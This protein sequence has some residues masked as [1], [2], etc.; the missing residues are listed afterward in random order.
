MQATRPGCGWVRRAPCGPTRRGPPANGPRCR[1][2]G[3]F[4]AHRLGR[5]GLPGARLGRHA[6][7]A[8]TSG[9]FPRWIRPDRLGDRGRLRAGR[10][11]GQPA[12]QRPRRPPG[13]VRHRRSDRQRAE[14]PTKAS[15]TFCSA[16]SIGWRTATPSSTF[17]PVRSSAS[18]SRS[19]PRELQNL[20]YC[21]MFV[22]PGAAALLG[23][24]RLLDPPQLSPS[25]P[26]PHAHQSHARPALPERR[27]VFRHLPFR[28][29]AGAP[30]A[31]P[32][33][34]G[35]ACWG[36]RPRTSAPWMWRARRPAVSFS[37]ERRGDDWLLTQPIEW[38]AN[39]QRGEPHRQRSAIPRA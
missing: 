31:S 9:P 1:H 8:W 36:P 30:R 25:H 23:P 24:R 34:S 2:A 15:S 10:R 3:R 13:R 26:P 7:P 21:L 32:A 22:L 14:S 39:P 19:A 29:R 35:A 16:R 11:P 33:R 17:P 18:S 6:T 38:R 28:A 27:P 4:I 20:R 37:L 5:G 12:L